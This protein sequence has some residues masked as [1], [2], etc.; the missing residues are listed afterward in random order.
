M[1]PAAL[2]WVMVHLT[3]INGT[4]ADDGLYYVRFV[5]GWS[6]MEFVV[7]AGVTSIP[8]QRTNDDAF[9]LQPGQK[10]GYGGT[11]LVPGVKEPVDED[12]EGGLVG[13][14]EET[15][16]PR[17]R[18]KDPPEHVMAQLDPD[19]RRSFARLWDRIP[20]HLQEKNFDFEPELWTPADNDTAVVAWCWYWV[21]FS[22]YFPD[23]LS[24]FHSRL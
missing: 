23:I 24:V 7:E 17:D 4:A 20:P 10:L 18:I 13:A 1:L 9:R 6:P 14:V 19:L 15:L 11:K 5:G 2:S 22:V 12:Q 3:N 21:S 8:L 16:E